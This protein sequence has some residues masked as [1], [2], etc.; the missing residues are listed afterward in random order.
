M[1]WMSEFI[2][3][4]WSM[5]LANKSSFDAMISASV[6]SGACVSFWVVIG[7]GV[8]HCVKCPVTPFDNLTGVRFK[9]CSNLSG[10]LVTTSVLVIAQKQSWVGHSVVNAGGFLCFFKCVHCGQFV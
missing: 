9:K 1:V 2:A 10:Y 6:G 5:I 7:L 4:S 3:S 8:G